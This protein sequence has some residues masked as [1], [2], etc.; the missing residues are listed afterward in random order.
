VQQRLD[1]IQVGADGVPVIKKGTSAV[2][3]PTLPTADSGFKAL[4]GIYVYTMD[5]ARDANFT[6]RASEI[7]P[8]NPAAPVQPIN[9]TGVAKTL[10]KLKAGGSVNIA[11]FGDSITLGAE[12]GQWWSDRSKTYTGKVIAGLKTKYPS[13]TITETP[14]YQGSLSATDAGAATLFTNS[15]LN[16]AKPVDLVI[17][18]LGMNDA[19]VDANGNIDTS[20]FSSAITSFV[21]QAKAKGIEVLLVSPIQ[22]NPFLD[23]LSAKAPRSAISTALKTIANTQ[24]VAMADV[25]TE[26]MNQASLGI[27]P[28][29]QLHNWI[30]HPGV[31]GHTLYAN[32]ILRLF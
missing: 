21:T 29:S 20:A 17:I 3:A 25:Y 30:N 16:A 6:I 27:P 32:T 15:V 2:V 26:W 10:A 19:G 31:N 18:A 9:P 1:L 4:A 14:A 8:I 11:E 28:Y 13:A 22:S 12:A 5:G 7:F 23:A 24:G